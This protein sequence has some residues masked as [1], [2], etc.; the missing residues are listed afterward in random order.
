MSEAD[1]FAQTFEGDDTH[2]RIEKGQDDVSEMEDLIPWH[3]D[4]FR[5]KGDAVTKDVIAPN[6]PSPVRIG[7]QGARFD[8][9]LANTIEV[10]DEYQRNLN[11][12]R[13][14]QIAQSLDPD[15]FNTITLSER[16]TGS[17]YCLD[18]QH[19]IAAALLSHPDQQVEVPAFIYTGL[20]PEDEARVFWKMNKHRLS[21]TAGDAFKARLRFGDPAAKT[22][23]DTLDKNGINIRYFGLGGGVLGADEVQAI[24]ECERLSRRGLLDDTLW[25]IGVAWRGEKGAYKAQYLAGIAQFLDLFA[26]ELNDP[27]RGEGRKQR[28]IDTLAILGPVGIDK[29]AAFYRENVGSR[30]SVAIARA[31]HARYNHHLRGENRLPQWGIGDVPG[32]E[33]L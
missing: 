23:K 1:L 5:L 25:T 32:D 11:A 15:A 33:D 18:G 28:V 2:P 19:R 20:S 29:T 27:K 16:P 17:L 31:I 6:M 24:A 22:V 12:N 9:V 21:P 8:W 4:S 10:D 7:Y 30:H 14:N 13:V 26:E 3:Y